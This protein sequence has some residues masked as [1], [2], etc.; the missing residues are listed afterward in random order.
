MADATPTTAYTLRARGTDLRVETWV[1]KG[2]KKPNRARL[3]ID[4]AEVEEGRAD[5]IGHVD[6]GKEAGHPTR[7]AWWWTG[8]VA[9]CA[10]VE[11]RHR[12]ARTRSTPYA[13]PPGT[14]A[15]RLHAW[16]EAH[17]TLYAPDTSSSSRRTAAAVLGH[18]ALIQA[19]HHPAAPPHRSRWLPE[20]RRAGLAESTSIRPLPGAPLEWVPPLWT[21]C[22]AGSQT[23][24]WMAEIRDRVPDRGLRGDPGG[25]TAQATDRGV[26]ATKR[27]A[28]ERQARERR[29]SGLRT[30]DPARHA[31]RRAA[32][33]AAAAGVFAERGYTGATTA[34]IC[35]A[36]GVGS[37]TLFH[38]FGDKRS[39]MMSIFADDFTVNDE[40]IAGLDP[41]QP[42]ASVALWTIWSA[43][44]IPS[45]PP[46][47]AM[48]HLA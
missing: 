7:V 17:P 20:P 3:L 46:G 45:S 19:V 22:S 4:G 37:G 44:R 35:R 11:P 28:R 10:L 25:T 2:E 48:L 41:D 33:Q 43:S 30:V 47:G 36:A 39:I 24:S 9:S 13:P 14:R 21:G 40:L 26:G 29:G 16:G 32:I 42:V 5:E 8:R 27:Q 23:S 15:A 1:A 18:R 34:Q 38:Y 12:E 31:A 6:L